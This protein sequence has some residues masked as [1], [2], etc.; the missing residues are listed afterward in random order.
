MGELHH[1]TCLNQLLAL[2]A[3]A[4]RLERR[5]LADEVDRVLACNGRRACLAHL[6]CAC[7]AAD[8]ASNLARRYP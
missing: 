4:E 7:I 3:Q 6:T 2:S 5:K 8:L 1:R